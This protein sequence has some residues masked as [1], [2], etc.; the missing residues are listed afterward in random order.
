MATDTTERGL[1][2]L[3]VRSLT[4]QQ[5]SSR[6]AQ[7]VRGTYGG[8]GYRLGDPAD[9]DREHAL[10]LKQLLAF[11]QETQA[12]VVE[13]LGIA[14]PGP[15]RV[16]FLARLT[17][18]IAKRGVADVLRRGIHH[19]PVKV[20]LYYVTP[21]PDNPEAVARFAA[22]RFTVTRQLRYSTDATR[23]ALDLALFIN[24]LPVVTFELK[25]NL[26]KQNVADA[27]AQYRKD[28]DPAERLFQFG[29]CLVHLAV[30]DQEVQF[31]TELKGKDSWFLPFNQGWQD[32]PGNPPNPNGIKTDYLWR[33]VLTRAGLTEILERY[34]Q[35]V[36]E[37]DERTGRKKR[38]QIFPRYHQRDVVRAV[39]AD[40]MTRGVGHRYLIQH[41]AGSGKSNSIAWTAHQLS[42]L[43]AEGV[44]LFDSVV[45]VTDRTIL[46]RQIRDTIRQFAQVSSILGH[47]R[48]SGDLKRF[49][50][51]GKRIIVTTVQ[52]FPVIVAEM[53]AEHRARRFAI[54]IDEAHSSQG[55]RAATQMNIALSPDGEEAAGET[56]EDTINRLMESGKMLKNASYFAF[57]A[58]PKPKTAQL[59][60]ELVMQ[61]G[62]ECY[63]PF[64][65]YTMKQA[66][67][68]RFILDVLAHYTPVPSFYRL[69][70]TV[71]DDPLFDKKKALKKL[72]R[73]VEGN[74]HAI[75]TK[76]EIMVDHF[77]DQVIARRKLG[78]EA[79]AMIVTAGI[80]R[81]I[82]YYYAVSAYLIDRKS[83]YQA[84][85]AFS[86]A[87]DYKGKKVTEA[88][89]NGF[90][91][92]LIPAKVR[93][94]P[95]R[96]LIVAEK[97]QTGFDEPLLHTM[98]V[99]KELAGIKAVQ[100]LSRLNRA[101]PGK[102]DTCVLDFYN[103]ADTI[104][105][106]FQPYYRT[107]ILSGGTDPNRLHDLKADLDGH[108]VY[109][110]EEIDRLVA[111]YLS[112]A[113]RDRLDP[114]LDACRAR[115]L[116]DLDEDA[117]V[118]FK[119][120][121]KAFLRTYGFLSA[122]LPYSRAV[123]EKLSI[124]LHLL[125]PRLPAPREEDD[126][127]AILAMVDMDSYRSERQAALTIQLE[128]EDGTL[129]P[130]DESGAS[131]KS[132]P[133]QERLSQI[134]R[135]FNERWGNTDW[136]DRDRVR[137]AITTEV[138]E[139]LAANTAYRNAMRNANR[140]KA[141]IEHDAALS[142][143]M[144]GMFSEHPELFK[145]FQ[146]DDE[147]RDWLSN[148]V[149]TTTYRPGGEA[150]GVHAG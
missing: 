73:Y 146:D 54:I 57:T 15:A 16:K 12:E 106:A 42:Q 74:D 67:E 83:P 88:A 144:L 24:G 31:C 25:N 103:D 65:S 78:G 49:I 124:F 119:G 107:T 111:L 20:E 4:G 29:R 13:Q 70:A 53:G 140:D 58:T 51:A 129:D 77:L 23:L 61:D 40:V 45:V 141:R 142:E 28:R 94:D 97:F 102:L 10:D 79:R 69:A 104:Q 84:I 147:F 14:T 11:L 34:A 118:E 138:P 1:E 6:D 62:Q 110:E 7:D 95:Y 145:R 27:V 41:S 75:R 85:V 105:A 130:Y 37:R 127:G 135:E 9:F 80:E 139:R 26:T 87:P 123:W 99:D 89:I 36:E 43:E 64:H 81:A 56:M 2:S 125:V 148:A 100:T 59:F 96:F 35:I 137:Q 38:R 66:I 50:A 86:G 150:P 30:D 131:R 72:K 19:G 112:N 82:D 76:A 68:E 52:K 63:V 93:E 46:D 39:L 109:T 71:E 122:I 128:D 21:S 149:F 60:G 3:I 55:G 115:Y 18:E 90:P 126:S 133:E 136:Q 120:K 101:C 121:A 48:H 113:E 17:G 32:G 108:G 8:G 22:N 33:E 143:V 132:E 114:I 5:P 98:F 116:S 92:H 117:Q 44:P 134:V 91:S 47:A